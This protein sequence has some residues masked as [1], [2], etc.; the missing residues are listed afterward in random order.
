MPRI[1]ELV[2][3]FDF[4]AKQ[5]LIGV[6]RDDDE[7]GTG[8]YSSATN[9]E[10]EQFAREFLRSGLLPPKLPS[11]RKPVRI[12][13]TAR[14]GW[15]QPEE[16]EV[17]EKFTFKNR[18]LAKAFIRGAMWAG[19]AHQGFVGSEDLSETDHTPPQN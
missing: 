18:H 3:F 11:K 10:R 2:A 13:M 16:I 7:E 8:G 15:A 6:P 14:R 5:T 4:L 9:K 12:M 1:E 17:K 19:K